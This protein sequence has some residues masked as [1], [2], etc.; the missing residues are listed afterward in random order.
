MDK[1]SIIKITKNIISHIRS[2]SS[3]VRDFILFGSVLRRDFNG[4]SDI[5]VL[6]IMEEGYEKGIFA[7]NCKRIAQRWGFEAYVEPLN[8][9]G[10]FNISSRERKTLHILYCK[11]EDMNLGLP[12]VKSICSN[13]IIL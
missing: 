12:V 4:Y 6:A 8:Q 1:A 13:G 5:D 2:S 9:Y 3:S 7:K 11:P 10:R